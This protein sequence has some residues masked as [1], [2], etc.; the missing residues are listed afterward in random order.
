MGELYAM[1][2]LY[3]LALDSFL[4]ADRLEV[5]NLEVMSAAAGAF[6]RLNRNQESVA[7]MEKI[8]ALHPDDRKVIADLG[9]M[10]FKTY[11]PADGERLLKR[12]IDEY[13]ETPGLLMTLG[14]LY[15]SLYRYEE[16]REYYLRSIEAANETGWDYFSAVAYYNLALLD[17]SFYQYDLAMENAGNSLDIAKRSSGYI[18][19]G[20]LAMSRMDFSGAL[21]AFTQAYDQDETPLS[22]ESLAQLYY[23]F[24]MLGPA[25]SHAKEAE[26]RAD[27]SWMYY[28]G[29]DP[30]RH[31]MDLHE[32][33]GDIYRAMSL[34]E[35]RLPARGI[36]RIPRLFNSIK[37]RLKSW[38][39][40]SSYRKLAVR[41]G[42]AYLEE[43]NKFDGELLFYYAL[44]G[45]PHAALKYLERCE[46]FEVS[47]APESFP[48]YRYEEGIMKSDS[49]LLYE[50]LDLLDPHWERSRI[51]DVLTALIPLVK[52]DEKID[53]LNLLYSINPGA[54]VRE[55]FDLPVRLKG[56]NSEGVAGF[57]K[58]GGV[59]FK[60]ETTDKVRYEL[61]IE[62]TGDTCYYSFWDLSEHKTIWTDRF[63][64]QG[65]GDKLSVQASEA[66]LNRLFTPR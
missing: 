23:Q 6:A 21:D 59:N 22:L 41:I 27:S 18:C 33:Y 15:T 11:R 34:N 64:F 46:N 30:D 56:K 16:G 45:Y 36:K 58:R 10:Y 31:L 2:E 13:G 55:G 49:E 25:L 42:R 65:D 60:T 1:E 5:D 17:Y 12:A 43:G 63:V 54:F 57:L 7:L 50:A 20:E 52:G 19:L 61:R 40:H 62:V 39:Y 44:K 3:H 4:Q 26:A 29:I 35:L 8:L 51:D 24:G 28:F 47:V 53:A 9:W 32:L 14:T 37:Y 66:I 38:F 48:F